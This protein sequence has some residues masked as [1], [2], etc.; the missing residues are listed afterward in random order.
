ML[1]NCIPRRLH[2]LMCLP[3]TS[4]G[5]KLSSSKQ[6]IPKPISFCN[7]NSDIRVMTGLPLRRM[8]TITEYPAMSCYEDYRAKAVV[9][10]PPQ[11]NDTKS[12]GEV[13]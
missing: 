8:I 13:R 3:A 2:L 6:I 9:L 4:I 10:L 7:N 11:D 1:L 5:H 12:G